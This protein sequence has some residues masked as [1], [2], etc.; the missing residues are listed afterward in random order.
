MREALDALQ[1]LLIAEIATVGEVA[2]YMK[3]DAWDLMNK[4]KTPFINLTNTALEITRVPGMAFVDAER[5]IMEFQL[6]Y[7]V[8]AMDIDT[9]YTSIDTLSDDIITALKTDVTLNDTVGGL[10]PGEEGLSWVAEPGVIQL[11][12]GYSAGYTMIVRY[13]VDS[14]K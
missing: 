12:S 8:S 5:H 2:T 13:F 7:A 6:E 4:G 3:Q 9:L 11:G 1:T 10:V 14:F